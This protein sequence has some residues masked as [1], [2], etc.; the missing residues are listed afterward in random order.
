MLLRKWFNSL[1]SPGLDWIQVEVTS[2][3]NAAC[4]YCPRTVYRDVW[5]NRNLPLETFKRLVPAFPKTKM[6][7]L[8]GWGEPFLHPELMTMVRIAKET[9]CRVGT[10]TNGMLLN[11][12]VIRQVVESG[13]DVLALSLAGID[14]KNDMLRRGTSLDALLEALRILHYTKMRAG[15][16]LPAVHIAYMLLRSGLGEIE[17]LPLLL[18]GL[19][20]SQVVVSTLDFVPCKELAGETVFPSS[21]EEYQDLRARLDA[22]GEVMERGGIGF[23][24]RLRRPGE[25][26]LTC[27]ENIQRSMFLSADGSVSPCV[28]TNLPISGEVS[29][30]HNG[31]QRYRRLTF[32]NVS[33]ASIGRIWR[34][35]EY[36]DF[37]KAF[38]GGSLPK[39][40]QG[41]PKLFLA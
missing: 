5:L 39:S 24:Y 16:N 22:V 29:A 33:D 14:E 15:K 21:M 30:Y 37:R 20:I 35:R 18:Q 8:Q 28:F 25:P 2:S 31:V 38:N 19:D 4:S 7:Y 9:G 3:C 36:R 13:M 11:E 41:C 32:G 10:T 27:T 6:V 23:H 40:C 1:F 34:G 17:R 26:C 12:S